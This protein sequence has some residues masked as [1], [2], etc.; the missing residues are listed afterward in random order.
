MAKHLLTGLLLL[1]A[2]AFPLFAVWIDNP[3]E[4]FATLPNEREA[5]QFPEGIAADA[6]GRIYVA[7][8]DFERPVVYVFE[9][10]GKRRHTIALPAGTVP[11]GLEI[12]HLGR[13]YVADFAGGTVLRYAQ[14]LQASGKPDGEFS[15]CALP[16]S[17]CGLNALAFDTKG[18]LYV[19]DSLGGN[20]FRIDLR[21]GTTSIFLSAELL[22]PGDGFP[23]LGAN[24]L[25]FD[26]GGKSLYVANTARESV[27]RYDLGTQELDVFAQGIDGADSIV[28]DRKGRLWVAASQMQGVIALD[29]TGT[30]IERV[31][32][33]DRSPASIV[34]SGGHVYVTNR[35]L[36][37]VSR[38][39]LR[40]NE[41]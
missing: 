41:S 31:G 15:V 23:P 18:D 14:P 16:E 29:E 17:G 4:R 28:F 10:N 37:T 19:S 36:Y 2:L 40:G 30:V 20:V 8:F 25:A 32:S 3:V 11:L 24:G 22:K 21:G 38:F 9:A 12:D 26:A 27:L 7:T 5:P 34:I 39:R 35:G 1:S 13:L 6:A 33:F